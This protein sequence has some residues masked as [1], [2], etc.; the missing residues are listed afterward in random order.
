MFVPKFY[1]LL[2]ILNGFLQLSLAHKTI[3]EAKAAEHSHVKKYHKK[4]KKQDGA[5]RLVGGE[6]DYEGNKLTTKFNQKSIEVK[7]ESQETLKFCMTENGETFA[8]TNGMKMRQKSCVDSWASP[9]S[10]K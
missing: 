1:Y 4:L 3:E 6:G 5:I 8:T 7:V 9:V 2:L 10:R